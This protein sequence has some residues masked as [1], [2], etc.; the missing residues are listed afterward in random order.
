MSTLLDLARRGGQ[1][2]CATHSPVLASLPGA[3][4]L[5][6]GEWGLRETAWED[7]ELVWHWRRF[8]DDARGLPAAPHRL[9]PVGGRRQ[10][11]R[12]RARNIASVPWRCGQSWTVP[13]SGPAQSGTSARR[14]AAEVSSAPASASVTSSRL[15]SS[16]PT[17]SRVS[18]R[19]GEQVA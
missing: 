2:L 12:R 11:R 17:T 5:E 8:L 10:A 13:W 7:L 18:A 19:T 4:L 9:R 15:T 3:R 16:D 1:V 14:P 6:V